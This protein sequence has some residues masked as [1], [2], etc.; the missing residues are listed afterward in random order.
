MK[1]IF[2]MTTAL[3]LAAAPVAFAQSSQLVKQTQSMLEEYGIPVDAATLEVTQLTALQSINV[4]DTQNVG[5]QIAEIVGYEGMVPADAMTTSEMAAA[6]SEAGEEVAEAVEANVPETGTDALV[7]S[8]LSDFDINVDASDLTAAQKVEILSLDTADA[9]N[10][11]ER[12]RSI[13]NG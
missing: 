7:E 10:A 8:V 6:A 9:R 3:T 12:L 4:S 5:A 13:I 1:P 11:E 2:A